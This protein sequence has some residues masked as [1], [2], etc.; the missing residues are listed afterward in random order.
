MPTDRPKSDWREL[1]QLEKEGGAARAEAIV[2]V[3]QL[4]RLRFE[5]NHLDRAVWP[6]CAWSVHG[7][8][9]TIGSQNFSAAPRPISWATESTAGR[10]AQRAAKSTETWCEEKQ[11]QIREWEVE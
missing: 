4:K 9:F 8:P 11:N 7:I 6:G 10:V 2:V 5:N 1:Q 3:E